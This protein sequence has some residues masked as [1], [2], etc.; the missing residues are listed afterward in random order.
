MHA[1]SRIKQQWTSICQKISMTPAFFDSKSDKAMQC[2]NLLGW[3]TF[4]FVPWQI[5]LPFNTMAEDQDTQPQ[6]NVNYDHLEAVL[7][8]ASA[9]TPLAERFRALFTL[10]NIADERSINIIAKGSGK[11]R[12]V[13]T[14]RVLSYY[15]FSIKRWVCPAKAWAD[16][17]LGSDW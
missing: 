12:S 1:F 10:K 7:C 4:F 3:K 17:L 15:C 5:R 13:P 11:H 14:Q 8:N 16:V 2:R 9:Q 6:L